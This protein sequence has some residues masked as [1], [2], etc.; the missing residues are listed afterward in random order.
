MFTFYEIEVFI[1]EYIQ[2]LFYFTSNGKILRP[3][4]PTTLIDPLWLNGQLSR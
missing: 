4:S 1:L 3:N 2:F